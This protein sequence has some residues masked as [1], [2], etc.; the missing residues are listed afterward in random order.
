LNQV[1]I[2]FSILARRLLKRPSFTSL[3][4][5]RRTAAFI[6]YFNDVFTKPFRWTD[7]GRP[8]R[9][10]PDR[11]FSRGHL[12]GSA[13]LRYGSYRDGDPGVAHCG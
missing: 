8:L 2:W 13:R 5:L 7:T 10:W 9:A 6:A 1:E 4:N 11:D 12:A 3:K